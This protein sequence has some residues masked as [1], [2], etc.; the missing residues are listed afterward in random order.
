MGPHTVVPT[1]DTL[2]TIGVGWFLL[3][4]YFTRGLYRLPSISPDSLIPLFP[5]VKDPS[6][7]GDKDYS[8][9]VNKGVGGLSLLLNS[10]ALTSKPKVFGSWT[11]FPPKDPSFNLPNLDRSCRLN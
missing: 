6:G 10:G 11:M 2:N 3:L 4:T 5:S 1:G 9:S 8:S 7:R